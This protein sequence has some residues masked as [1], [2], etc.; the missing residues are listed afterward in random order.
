M[1]AEDLPFGAF[2][3]FFFLAF[4]AGFLVDSSS[5]ALRFFCEGGR[6]A[7]HRWGRYHVRY[8]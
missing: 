1:N 8:M 5:S 7:Y 2:G 4:F 3:S 6:M